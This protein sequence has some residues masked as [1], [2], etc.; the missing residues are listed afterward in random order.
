ME[1]F[2]TGVDRILVLASQ[3]QTAILKQHVGTLKETKFV[4]WE[5]PPIV[6]SVLCVGKNNMWGTLKGKYITERSN[7]KK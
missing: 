3:T 4:C 2:N 1:Q 5:K 7:D 6:G